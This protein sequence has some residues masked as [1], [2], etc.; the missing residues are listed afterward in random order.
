MKY[1]I[2]V[3][4]LILMG[5]LAYQF[6][7]TGE[8]K[9]TILSLESALFT[10][11]RDTLKITVMEEG[12]LKA[13]NSE[14]LSPKFRREGTISTLIEEGTE[15]KEG[16]VLVEF[17]K[18]DIQNQIDEAENRLL[19]NETQLEADKANLEIQKRDNEANKEKAQLALDKA[20]MEQE[21][22]EKG[23]RP[24]ELRKL[25]VAKD[26]AES[27]YKREEERFKEVPELVKEGYLTK[28]DEE[29]QRIKVE[30][31]R[32]NSIN[33]KKDLELFET[34][35][36]KMKITELKTAVNDATR[37]LKNAHEKAEIQRKEKEARV[38]RQ[39]RQV[40]STK[41]KLDKLKEEMGYMTMKAPQNGIVHY[42][43]PDHGWWRME[44]IK[45]GGRIWPGMTIITLP[46]LSL[47]QV[48][49]QVHEADI[50][51][52]QE[53]QD[54]LI[55]VETVKERTFAGKVTE[56]AS[57][58]ETNRGD[59]SNK[60]FEV[61]ID[62]DQVEDV[63][64]RSGISAKAEILVEEV[65]DVKQ[66]PIHAIITEGGEHFC[67]VSENGG[68][69]KRVVRIGKNNAHYVEVLEGLEEGEQVLL[70]DPRDA[71]QF[72]EKDEK[73]SEEGTPEN[74]ATPAESMK[75]I[76]E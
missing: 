8:E 67:Y 65:P 12:F 68:M 42:G 13:K 47:M 4:C 29:D 43:D 62:M 75:G 57:V 55:T 61:T 56:I 44:E 24:N 52:V 58:A 19:E 6:E 60:T 26:K 10:V 33:A 41:N 9:E 51:L 38:T 30:E 64:F 17:E 32:I 63:K 25:K 45:V 71:G 36:D 16:D 39:Q 49:V 70:Y 18:T 23:E 7:W 15:V 31:A 72:S 2:T 59:K 3:A 53:G 1:A 35:T 69:E 22:Y 20:K 5:F 46:D 54:V 27:T 37:E 34:Y 21:K 28:Y 74:G 76:L 40:T 73:K 66:V 14:K 11:R 48:V 50:D